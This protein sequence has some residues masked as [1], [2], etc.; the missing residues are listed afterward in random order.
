MT[1]ETTRGGIDTLDTESNVRSVHDQEPVSRQRIWTVDDVRG[2][3]VRTDLETAASVFGLGRTTAYELART[4]QFPCKLIRV[5]HK[6]V[7]PVGPMLVALGIDPPTPTQPGA[8]GGEVDCDG[9][10]RTDP[11]RLG[12]VG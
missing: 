7:V 4:G 2:L 12:A 9:T 5:G 10:G 8:A 6:Y 11:P 3:G 1:D